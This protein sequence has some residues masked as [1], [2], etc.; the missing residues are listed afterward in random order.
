[1]N[2]GLWV[3]QV[4]LGLFMAV[5]S[6][7]PKLIIPVEQLPMPIPIPGPLLVFIGV[8]E[9]AGGLGLILPGLFKIRPGLTPL[10]AAGLGLVAISGMAYQVAAGEPGNAVFALAITVLC[11]LVGYG[12]WQVA[13][14][15][16][17][18]RRPVLQAVS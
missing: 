7:L 16:A 10:A 17:R 8:A 9:I 18:S 14:H 13:P 12:R 4:L 2:V 15:R 11:A 3:L 1:M 5:A 6:G